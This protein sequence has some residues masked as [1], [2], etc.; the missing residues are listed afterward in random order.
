MKKMNS[1]QLLEQLQS[2]T[3]ELI[4]TTLRFR[5]EDPGLLLS[6]PAP[7]KWSVTQ[8][9]EHINSYGHY[10]LPA[11]EASM[12]RG[13]TA[14]KE[15]K[16][17][18][19]G[20]YFTRLMLPDDSGRVRSKMKAPKAH[21]PSLRAD[22]KPVVE[23]FLQQQ[24]RLLELLETAKEKNIGSIRVPI[25][26]SKLV[27]LKLG[28][29]FRF[30]IAHEQRHFLQISNTLETLRARDRSPIG[31]QAASPAPASSGG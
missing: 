1:Q 6:T 18:W 11:I 10:Y 4:A 14:T 7:G 22:A 24:Y 30:L 21:R 5:A 19:L 16:P 2:D 29:T 8:V 31:R 15:F 3:R 9:L 27:R 17:G 23:T 28:D 12:K 26:I 20:D 13:G 25:S